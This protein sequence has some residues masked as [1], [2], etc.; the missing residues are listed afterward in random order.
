[1]TN[2]AIEARGLGIPP[3]HGLAGRT[4]LNLACT[5]QADKLCLWVLHGRT[6]TAGES[7][8]IP[9]QFYR[10]IARLFQHC[11]KR[12]RQHRSTGTRGRP[13]CTVASFEHLEELL[14]LSASLTVNNPA[15]Y[16][17]GNTNTS[18]MVFTV[19]R[20]GDLAPTVKVDFATQDGSAKSGIDYQPVS[21]TLVFGP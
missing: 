14:V 11:R 20:S 1:F 19:T 15:P 9:F 18:D 2:T 3:V 12:G 5:D 13:V 17:E 21:G 10:R 8:L 4:Q 7:K 6:P 16:F